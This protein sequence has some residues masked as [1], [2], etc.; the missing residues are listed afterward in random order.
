MKKLFAALLA[1]VASIAFGATTLPVQL[2]NPTGSTSGQAIVSTGASSVPA[3]ASVNAA[4]LS[5]NAIG[6]SGA[7]VPLLSG[8]NSWSGVNTFT[9]PPVLQGITSGANGGSGI[10]GQCITSGTVGPVT[11]TTSGTLQNITSV[12]LTAGDWFVNASIIFQ[13]TGQISGTAAGISTTSTTLP[14]VPYYFGSSAT[15]NAGAN[16]SGAIPMQ[17]VN[18]SAGATYYLNAQEN[19]TTGGTVT[20]QMIACRWH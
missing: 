7:A 14:P 15:L 5:G 17:V 18:I 6:T 13:T 10:V 8:T 19:Y 2:I 9:A 3:W 12:A 4:T 11:M 16:T 1:L 20:A